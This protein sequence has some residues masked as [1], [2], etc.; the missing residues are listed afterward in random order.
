MGL[1]DKI[2]DKAEDLKDDA[3]EAAGKLK[4]KAEPLIDKAQDAVD[5]QLHKGDGGTPA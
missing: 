4:E 5:K 1:I 3:V 2:K